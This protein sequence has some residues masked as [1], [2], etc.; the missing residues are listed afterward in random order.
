MCGNRYNAL[1]G[2]Y[3]GLRPCEGLHP[4]LKYDALS[5]LREIGSPEGAEYA[6]DV[7]KPIVYV[8]KPIVYVVQPIVNKTSSIKALKGRNKAA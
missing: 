4:S 2:L 8:A 7:A 3:C 1:A 6:N 5:G